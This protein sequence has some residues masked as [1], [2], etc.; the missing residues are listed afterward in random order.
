MEQA[1]FKRTFVLW[2]TQ[3]LIF[4]SQPFKAGAVRGHPL[5]PVSPQGQ[6]WGLAASSF[7]LRHS[8]SRSTPLSQYRG[9]GDLDLQ[10]CTPLSSC[11]TTAFLSLLATS[12]SLPGGDNPG[13]TFSLG[14]SHTMGLAL[15]LFLEIKLRN[16]KFSSAIS[17]VKTKTAVTLNFIC[18]GTVAKHCPS[19]RTFHQPCPQRR[20]NHYSLFNCIIWG[21]MFFLQVAGSFAKP[22]HFP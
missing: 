11:P 15:D 21:E 17:K 20:V 2:G 22:A 1:L 8:G 4:S 14:N 16:N 3:A 13:Q 18:S 19:L 5:T 6:A 7:C 10:H 12:F 9:L